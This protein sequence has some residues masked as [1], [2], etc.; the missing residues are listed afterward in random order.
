MSFAHGHALV[1]GDTTRATDAQA[2]AGVLRDPQFCGYPQAQVTLVAGQ[3]T[4]DAVY[5][6]LDA[7]LQRVDDDTTAFIYI[8]GTPP[9]SARDMLAWLRELHVRHALLV[10]DLLADSDWL[11][12]DWQAAALATGAGRT[13]IV[14]GGIVATGLT[15]NA[16]GSGG[17]ALVLTLQG[18]A[19]PARA[20]YIGSF[21]LYAA[22]HAHITPSAPAAQPPTLYA[23]LGAPPFAV[24]LHAGAT[25][26]RFSAPPIP[27]KGTATSLVDPRR[28]RQALEQLLDRLAT[29]APPPVVFPPAAPGFE[30]VLKP[31]EGAA[32]AATPSV[33]K[34]IELLP[35]R[36]EAAM[37]TTVYVGVETEI[38]AVLALPEGEGLELPTTT[39]SGQLIKSGD[40]A[41]SE[42]SVPSPTDAPYVTVYLKVFAD[43]FV[44]DEES[45]DLDVRVYRTA[46][47]SQAVIVLTPQRTNERSRIVLR[48]YSDKAR[49]ERID[50]L[51]LYAHILE[52][53][54]AAT[55]STPTLA[56]IA[57]N[58]PSPANG[59]LVIHSAQIT[60]V[61]GDYIGGDKLGGDKVFG[62]K[63]GNH[64]R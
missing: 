45:S 37:P 18:V 63:H 36:F 10:L 19:V 56:P 49:T 33:P 22:L 51:T 15:A 29:A 47:S 27:P 52:R 12:P 64:S 58:I 30:G 2:I 9:I 57:L 24:A 44:V 43:D 41:D 50:S 38:R 16:L 54:A 31:N 34:N 26:G 20:G 53:G 48:I 5:G 39:A 23:L 8:G 6:A 46:R 62:D 7:F 11:P 13:V 35:R 4:S 25:P 32:G 60:I 55:T 3:A 42:V 61:G 21:E 40:I 17:Q 28:A 1:L 59:G 14:M